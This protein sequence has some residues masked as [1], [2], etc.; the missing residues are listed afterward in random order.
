MMEQVTQLNIDDIADLDA[1]APAVSMAGD[2][3]LEISLMDVVI[4]II[5]YP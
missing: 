5:A 4:A 1:T 2:D 3:A